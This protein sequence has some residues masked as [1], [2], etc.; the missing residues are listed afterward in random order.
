MISLLKPRKITQFRGHRGW[1]AIFFG[2]SSLELT[3]ARGSG[4]DV[5]VENQTSAP[6]PPAEEGADAKSR[7]QTAVQDLCQ[8]LDPR[9]HRI[10]TA[11]RGE[12]VLCQTL[13]LPATQMEELRQML[14]L[15]ID[16]LTPLPVEEVVY[17]FEPLETTDSETRVLVVVAPKAAVNE[18]VEVLEAAG[19][20]PEVVGVDILALFRGFLRSQLLPVDERL[21]TFVQ[22]GPT[23]ANIIVHTHGVPVAIRSVMLGEASLG[24][25]ESRTALREELQR[26]QVAAEA[27]QPDHEIGRVVLATWSENLRA[28]VEELARGWNGE[29]QCYTNGSVLSPGA[30]LCVETAAAD[31][32]RLNLLP[33]EWRQRRRVAQQRRRLI[34]GGI[35]LGA[36]YLLGL[37]VFL[38]LMGVRQSRLN[39]VKAK[40]AQSQKALNDARELNRL[41]VAMQKQLDTK[42]S[43]LEVLRAVSDV[44][45]E[46]VK[47]NGFTFK[48]DLTVGLKA[49]AQSAAI[50][51]D[52]ISRLER[53]ALFSK[54][55]LVQM[56]T[57]LP[58]AGGLTKFDVA[59]T[60]KSASP[61]PGGSTIWH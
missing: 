27:D 37:A 41:V 61:V 21:N 55:A 58:A 46:N 59:C 56:R 60:L 2:E 29:A 39:E 16:N 3:T 18:R 34:R 38:S 50:A 53:C 43:A 30:S 1:A 6:L 42:Y 54:V 47:L 17:S 14:D 32:L 26:T 4:V 8:K 12:D 7:W 9:E 28:D 52:F 15:Q 33:D 36:I 24:S 11:I 49:Q 44:M 45:P 48:R 5:S 57:D 13:R 23:A 20:P 22:I 19:F 31:A 40:I 35:V 25:V 51:N 10:V